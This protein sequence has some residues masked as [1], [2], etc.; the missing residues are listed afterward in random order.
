M[1]IVDNCRIT[2]KDAQCR[3]TEEEQQQTDQQRRDQAQRQTDFCSLTHP[4]KATGTDVLSGEGRDGHRVA[5]DRQDRKP[6]DLRICT[7]TGHGSR[8]KC[9]DV[10]LDDH[11]GKRDDRILYAAGQTD[12]DDLGEGRRVDL[13][14]TKTE[15]IRCIALHHQQTDEQG[16]QTL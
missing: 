9:V 11:V 1:P 10:A 13:Q 7:T 6:I 4:V 5:G 15:L 8:S 3:I 16:A 12:T 14:L 2:G